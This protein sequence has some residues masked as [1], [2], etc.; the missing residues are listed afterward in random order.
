MRCTLL[1]RALA[2]RAAEKELM[3]VVGDGWKE[4]DEGGDPA[5]PP[6]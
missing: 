1:A 2:L 6:R 3:Q 4:S 5:H